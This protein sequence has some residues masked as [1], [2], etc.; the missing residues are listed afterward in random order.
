MELIYDTDAN[1]PAVLNDY[2]IDIDE[3]KFSQVIRNLVSNALKFTPRGGKVCVR[4]FLDTTHKKLRVEVADTGVG[5]K[6]ANQ[7]LLFKKVIQFNA[8]KLQQGGGSG[9]GLWSKLC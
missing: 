2:L 9:L 8:N 5:I 3:K 7:E 1:I 4:A 6:H